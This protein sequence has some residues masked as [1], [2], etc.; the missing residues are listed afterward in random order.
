MSPSLIL[1]LTRHAPPWALLLAATLCRKSWAGCTKKTGIARSR[2][3]VS[4]KSDVQNDNSPE[5]TLQGRLRVK[6]DV[7]GTQATKSPFINAIFDREPLD[8]F[9]WGRVALLGEAA[10]PTTPH[11]L[12]RSTLLLCV[13][14]E[15]HL[16]DDV[17]SVIALFILGSLTPVP[18][19]LPLHT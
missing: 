5:T 15:E 2:V 8:Q 13:Q 18:S 4:P 14:Q 6:C 11:G 19:S 17:P 3:T 16:H 12:R 1:S 9:V 7:C 10:H